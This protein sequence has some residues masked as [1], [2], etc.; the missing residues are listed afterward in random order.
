[1]FGDPFQGAKIKGY[2]GPIL[3]CKLVQSLATRVGADFDFQTATTETPSAQE[4]LSS[5]QP[6]LHTPEAS[7]NKL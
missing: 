3:T 6:I 2:D 4:T 5:V 7:R 1:M